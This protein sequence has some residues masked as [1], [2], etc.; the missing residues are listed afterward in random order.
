MAKQRRRMPADIVEPKVDQRTMLM[1]W[2]PGQAKARMML[3]AAEPSIGG[4]QNWRARFSFLEEEEEELE[5][6]AARRW[7]ALKMKKETA[8]EG[9]REGEVGV[10]GGLTGAVEGRRSP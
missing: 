9:T 8:E 3:R 10:E 6:P 7:M 4:S 2:R 5:L 1:M